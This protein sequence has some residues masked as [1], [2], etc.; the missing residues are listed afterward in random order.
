MALT[1]PEVTVLHHAENLGLGA[2]YRSGF[3]NARGRFITFFPADGQFPA[4]ILH[5][6]CGSAESVD[7]ILGYLPARPGAPFGKLL[8]GAERLLMRVLIGPLP[9]FQGVFL[10]RRELLQSI[11]L[12]SRGRGWGILMEMIARVSGAGCRVICQ[13][14]AYRPR[15]TG[16]SKVMNGRTVVSNFRQL[17][18]L[19]RVLRS[20][21]PPS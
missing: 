6:F 17:L 18:E 15:T 19:R 16:H 21:T 20:G 13:P 7:L 8:S 5:G 2:V 14:T 10:L 11:T 12:A 9:R 1:N 4:S 3:D